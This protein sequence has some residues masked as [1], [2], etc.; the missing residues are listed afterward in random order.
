LEYYA[1]FNYLMDLSE[2]EN[3]SKKAVPKQLEESVSSL[4]IT[5][6]ESST[7]ETED[8]LELSVAS[9]N[10][11]DSLRASPMPTDSARQSPTY[12]DTEQ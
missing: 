11:S 5:E 1:D 4:A 7:T 2:E 10:S 6:P 3:S 9:S 12:P 8:E